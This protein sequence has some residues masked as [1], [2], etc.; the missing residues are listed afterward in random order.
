[1]DKEHSGQNG[2]SYNSVS[3]LNCH[4]QGN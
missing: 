3:C 2:Y 4:P 1:M